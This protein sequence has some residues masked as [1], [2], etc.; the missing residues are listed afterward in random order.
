MEILINLMEDAVM[1]TIDELHRKNKFHL[2]EKCRLDIA[3]IA[4]NNLAPRYT[5]T[6]K[7]SIYAKAELLELQRQIDLIG[8][9]NKAINIVTN[10]PRHV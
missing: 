10:N 4:L 6:Q 9:V 8:E 5:V 7:G 1:Q 2:C 3:A